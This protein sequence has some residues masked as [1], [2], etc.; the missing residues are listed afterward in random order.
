MRFQVIG[1]SDKLLE[2]LRD[3][4]TEAGGIR[5]Q[6]ISELVSLMS[7]TNGKLV[8]KCISLCII[9]ASE[10]QVQS[11]LCGTDVWDILLKWLQ[12]ALRE[13]N[14]SF[15]IELMQVYL[16]LPVSL[17]QLTRNVCPKLI[18]TLSKKSDNEGTGVP[19]LKIAFLGVRSLAAEI[20]RKW[21]SVIN[22]NS[23]KDN[24]DLKSKKRKLGS[25]DDGVSTGNPSPAVKEIKK[26]RTTVKVPPTVMRTAGIEEVNDP[27]APKS[28]SEVLAKKG[29]CYLLR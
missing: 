25:A 20:V 9:S 18:N 14:F 7:N 6:S 11:L 12:E 26:R 22:Q 24:T 3:H 27:V 13:E 2:S 28:R 23:R 10:A 5:E 15:L 21:K 16:D 4:L 17:E 8:P 29:Y 1:D 19:C